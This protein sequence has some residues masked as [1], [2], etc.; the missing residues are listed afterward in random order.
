MRIIICCLL[1]FL[2]FNVNAQTKEEKFNK[3]ITSFQDALVK[4]D[5]SKLISLIAATLQ[6]EGISNTEWASR[7][8]SDKTEASKINKTLASKTIKGIGHDKMKCYQ[9][10]CLYFD[11][12]NDKWLLVDSFED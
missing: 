3:Y 8:I 11:Y 1:S 5:K 2:V 4:K 7:I 10:I 12:N 9:S 6:G